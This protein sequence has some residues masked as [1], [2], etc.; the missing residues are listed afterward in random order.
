M[1]DGDS[2]SV[3]EARARILAA[4]APLEPIQLSLDHILGLVLA[5]PVVAHIDLP[6]FRNSAMDGYAVRA[7]NTSSATVTSPVA[8]RVVSASAAGDPP[9]GAIEVDEAVRI[10]TGAPLP[11]GADA[12][13]RF[14]DTDEPASH[15]EPAGVGMV[16]IF[17]P[18]TPDE[19]VR[20]AG[21]EL[22][23]G[24]TAL[25][26]V[27]LIGPAS[28]G[29]L[30]AL[31]IDR[32]T[33]DRRSRVGVLSTGSE[34]TQPGQPLNPG[35]IF[36]A[37]GAMIRALV[38]ESGAQAISLGLTVDHAD[39]INRRLATAGDVDLIIVSGGVS[40]GDYDLVKDVLQERGTVAVW[41]V[42]L[43]PGK[44]LAFGAVDGVP[45][46][47][48]PGNPVAAAVSFELFARLLL[49]K[50]AGRGDLP[51][52][53]LTARL[54]TRIPNHGG[55]RQY[56]RISLERDGDGDLVAAALP[57]QS[58]S[59]LSALGQAN[60]LIEIPETVDVAEAGKTFRVIVLERD[61]EKLVSLLGT[62]I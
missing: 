23:S 58:T 41:Q 30:A 12:V 32:V 59:K 52:S 47:G 21:E 16:A 43:K 29:L 50:L 24:Q 60:A 7:A 15:R 36:D 26:S 22:R 11:G 6:P 44:A 9:G 18:V 51:T 42:R 37:N 62:S 40:V 27:T 55:R 35:H 17:R 57:D 10:M 3:D 54:V 14:E 46:L 34:L 56:A 4:I 53:S 49:A 25:P 61:P 20:A 2:L 45:L 38:A 39:E 1:P 31:G 13:V 28:I 33:V 19:N 5:E 48:L 8:L